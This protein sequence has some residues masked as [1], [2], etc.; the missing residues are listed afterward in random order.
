MP[1]PPWLA[2]IEDITAKTGNFKKFHVFVKMLL[3]AIKHASDSVFMDLLTYQDLEVGMS[4]AARCQRGPHI[5]WSEV[6]I[7]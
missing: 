1:T 7:V 2:D 4:G 5:A 3:S 6:R